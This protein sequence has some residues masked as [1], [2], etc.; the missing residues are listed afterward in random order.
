MLVIVR[1]VKAVWWNADVVCGEGKPCRAGG[2]IAN[3]MHYDDVVATDRLDRLEMLICRRDHDL[4]FINCKHM[5]NDR[6]FLHSVAKSISHK[7]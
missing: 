4:S 5:A 1:N 3:R 6:Y 7:L 2:K